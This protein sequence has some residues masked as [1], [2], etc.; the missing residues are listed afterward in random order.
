FGATRAGSSRNAQ[1]NP[2]WGGLTFGL[3]RN[4][5]GSAAQHAVYMS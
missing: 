4:A 1:C 5:R 3:S 2:A